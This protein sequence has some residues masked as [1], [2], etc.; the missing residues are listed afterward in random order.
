MRP[1]RNNNRAHFM[2]CTGEYKIASKRASYYS[3]NSDEIGQNQL[4]NLTRVNVPEAG[5]AEN[6]P[7][8]KHCQI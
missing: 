8:K 2:I 4:T 6:I 7:A 1:Q 5:R 3:P